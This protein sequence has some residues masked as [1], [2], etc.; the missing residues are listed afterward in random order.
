MELANVSRKTSALAWWEDEGKSNFPHLYKLA[1]KH[2]IVS[3]TSVPSERIFSNAGNILTAKR[4]RLSDANAGMLV[5]L[6]A[7][8]E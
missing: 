1:L 4:N 3:A 7:N 2:L 8:L 6:N 5:F